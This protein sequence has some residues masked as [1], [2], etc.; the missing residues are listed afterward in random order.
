M[1]KT[2]QSQQQHKQKWVTFRCSFSG[3]GWRRASGRRGADSIALPLS[4]GVHWETVFLY[5]EQWHRNAASQERSARPSEQLA[6]G[7]RGRDRWLW[8]ASNL[9]PVRESPSVWSHL[10]H[11]DTMGSRRA[12]RRCR[13]GVHGRG[14]GERPE[15]PSPGDRS[16]NQ[17]APLTHVG[18]LSES[19]FYRPSPLSKGFASFKAKGMHGQGCEHLFTSSAPCSLLS[20]HRGR[21]E[22]RKL[23]GRPGPPALS[24]RSRTGSP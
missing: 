10:E 13:P 4:R 14:C 3:G 17:R 19:L 24:R 11:E 20:K 21:A 2:Q 12:G 22:G 16:G 6:A 15:R 7:G 18:T 23:P 8:R 9:P 1:H 5:T